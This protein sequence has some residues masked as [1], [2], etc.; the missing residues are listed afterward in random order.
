MLI[1][2]RDLTPDVMQ[3]VCDSWHNEQSKLNGTGEHYSCDGCPFKL[4]EI[5]NNFITKD[6]D[7]DIAFENHS[8]SYCLLNLTLIL[9]NEIEFD[10]DSKGDE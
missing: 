2:V 7:D 6:S 10:N 8:F 4:V 1:K 5:K 3:K 9:D